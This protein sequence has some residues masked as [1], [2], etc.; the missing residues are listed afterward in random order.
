[1]GRR[2]GSLF[3]R[4]STVT[5]TGRT[6]SVPGGPVDITNVVIV[7]SPMVRCVQT[8]HAI[9][10]GLGQPVPVLIEDSLVESFYW[11][12]TDLS[13]QHVYAARPLAMKPLWHSP[14]EHHESTS[15][16]VV[17]THASL[18]VPVPVL[19]NCGGLSEQ[20]PEEERCARG[21]AKLLQCEKLFG[22]T[23]ILVTH[24]GTAMG[25]YRALTGQVRE[26]EPYYTAFCQLAPVAPAATDGK[27]NMQGPDVIVSSS[28]HCTRQVP[29]EQR[30][31]L[32]GRFFETPH[33][34]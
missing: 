16:L 30:F 27:E 33:L 5:A 9:A 20:E 17:P 31:K 7:S 10:E 13:R 21:T 15:S 28:A 29:D 2:L 12:Y 4:G 24:A 22:K 18:H 1:M 6:E 26:E 32:V 11:M 8:A 34:E 14:A 19:K 25:W 3:S 23:V